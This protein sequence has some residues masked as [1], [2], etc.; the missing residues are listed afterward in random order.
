MTRQDIMSSSND[1]AG[2]SPGKRRKENKNVRGIALTIILMVITMMLITNRIHT[3]SE[4][5][6]E[7]NDYYTNVVGEYKDKLH[8]ILS[9]DTILGLNSLK[10][11]SISGTTLTSSLSSNIQQNSLETHETNASSHLRRK[12][13]INIDNFRNNHNNSGH[14]S[15]NHHHTNIFQP[16]TDISIDNELK[17]LNCANQSICVQP[18]IQLTK[19]LNIYLCSHP[20]TY[21]WRFYYIVH[22]GLLLHP[23][24]NLLPFSDI[25]RA[26]FIIY[27][28]NSAPWHKTEC[29]SK[30]FINKLI[31]LDEYDPP[32]LFRPNSSIEAMK[33]EYGENM[34]W[35][36]MYFKRSFVIRKNG[37]FKGYPHL[38]LYNLYPLVY[39][40]SDKYIPYKFTFKRDIS[41]LCTLRGSNAMPT[42]QRVSDWVKEYAH[43][44]SLQNAIV[45]EVNTASRTAFSRGYFEKLYSTEIIVTVNPAHWEG[46]FRLWESMASGALVFVDPLHVPYP[47][48]LKDGIHA[49][50]YD[51]N[52]KTD[53]F[54][55]LD[56]YLKHKDRARQIAINGYLHSMKYHRT[57]N[58]MDYVLRSA[59]LHQSLL[60]NK[61]IPK[62]QF[63]AQFLLHKIT[64]K[65]H[66]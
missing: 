17:L 41:I 15:D 42:R 26:D 30:R 13:Q 64:G 34:T 20:V 51:N 32:S 62:Y 33:I 10:N 29:T 14:H 44:N 36:T 28:P 54:Q 21:G 40:I 49:I 56:F 59:H 39:S 11:D 19:R 22:E 25:D 5:D 48:P 47:Y 31:V 45:S 4:S 7:A 58:M 18:E 27:L 43:N 35:Y 50:F 46:D 53:L 66:V 38:K 9:L 55:K 65:H 8:D 37:Q 63:T 57:A 16:G 24:I 1:E 52:N 6:A 61:D 12:P 23:N 60:F 2:V 3:H